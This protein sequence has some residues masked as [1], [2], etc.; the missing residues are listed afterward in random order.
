MAKP[1][2][3][4]PADYDG[5]NHFGWVKI[6]TNDDWKA[7]ES[8][9]VSVTFTAKSDVTTSL[10]LD[11]KHPNF[12]IEKLEMEMETH[13]NTNFMEINPEY[14]EAGKMVTVKI[15]DN[16]KTGNSFTIVYNITTSEH[17]G[18]IIKAKLVPWIGV[19][20][21]Y[22]EQ[23]SEGILYY[24]DI[25]IEPVASDSHTHTYHN[26]KLTINNEDYGVLD[27]T[28]INPE[29]NDAGLAKIIVKFKATNTILDQVGDST[30]FKIEFPGDWR[31]D[32]DVDDESNNRYIESW[33]KNKQKDENN[34]DDWRE[35]DKVFKIKLKNYA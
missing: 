3:D 20:R 16:M 25:L 21:F 15:K 29:G 8:N 26:N 7:G 1:E 10:R 12:P 28:R 33:E 17:T 34:K 5:E 27:I 22:D 32:V 18:N 14:N 4:P 2:I 31:L 24:K 35:A 19:Y 30:F 23:D 13:T 9:Q 6:A 11:I